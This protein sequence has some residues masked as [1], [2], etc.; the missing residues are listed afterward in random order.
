MLVNTPASPSAT[1]SNQEGCP[2]AS[3]QHQALILNNQFHSKGNTSEDSDS[4]KPES[5]DTGNEPPPTFPPSTAALE[6]VLNHWW[7][8]VTVEALEFSERMQPFLDRKGE[9]K[10]RIARTKHELKCANVEL[11]Q[12]V[13]E[14]MA[15]YRPTM[16]A[17]EGRKAEIEAARVELRNLS[18]RWS[19][20]MDENDEDD[21]DE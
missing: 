16:D 4:D 19:T 2:Q 17:I 7:E 12:L 6:A 15:V 3:P 20:S 21:G 9:V 18:G 1:H 5:I 8:A 14:E 10:S 11:S 13:K